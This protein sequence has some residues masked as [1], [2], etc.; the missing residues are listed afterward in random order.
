MQQPAAAVEQLT[1]SGKDG[2]QDGCGETAAVQGSSVRP[3]PASVHDGRRSSSGESSAPQSTADGSG[4]RH[5]D[6]GRSISLPLI[7]RRLHP[8]TSQ[9]RPA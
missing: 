1:E 6:A 9:P 7:A 5:G 4:G 2:R 8:V 3:D